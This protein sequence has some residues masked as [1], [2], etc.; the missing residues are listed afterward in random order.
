MAGEVEQERNTDDQLR[1]SNVRV[2]DD[3]ETL[4]LIADPLR[5]R[6]LELL[7]A[8][9]RT[10]TELADLLDVQRTKLYYHVK[11]LEAHDLIAVDRTRV[12]S[13]ITE[14]R[15]RVTAYQLSVDK[16][17]LGAPDSGQEPLDLLLSFI[18]GEAAA[19]IRRAV[20]AGLIDLDRTQEDAIGPRRLVIGR[21][22]YRLTPADV[23]V[24]EAAYEEFRAKI[25]DLQGGFDPR[26]E[27][28]PG[29]GPDALLYE[30]LVAF[31]PIVSPDDEAEQ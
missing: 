17:L 8:Q 24:F 16:A 15:Y 28:D 9:P 14:K 13:G 29:G 4:R 19:D 30:W 18:L 23:E 3:P 7:R 5:L 31:Y 20:R 1:E 21:S 2:I 6:L 10:V 26:P 11:L 27:A 25:A 22:W 12:V